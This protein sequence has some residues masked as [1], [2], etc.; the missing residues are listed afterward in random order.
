MK[1]EFL[2]SSGVVFAFTVANLPAQCG[3]DV[4]ELATP[5][6]LDGL[7][8]AS[9]EWDRDGAGPLP[10]ELVIAGTFN[11]IGGVLVKGIARLDPAA[12]WQPLASGLGGAASS[13]AIDA[14]NH[15]LVG[16]A[17][18][19]AGG[20]AAP[21]IARFDGA[22]WNALA[23][24]PPALTGTV[25]SLVAVDATTLYYIDGGQLS[26]FDGAAVAGIPL[27]A[28]ASGIFGSVRD[29]ARLPNGNVLIGGS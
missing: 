15:L 6:N 8:R 26:V 3:I 28:G 25:T 2:A 7:I 20:V 12:G 24:S 17:F 11:T 14:N 27:A 9:I 10:P 23:A 22:Q 29:L 21:R 5:D 1:H 18:G 19:T 13:L 16:G 4:R